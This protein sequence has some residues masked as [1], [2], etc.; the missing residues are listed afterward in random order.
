MSTRR[1]RKVL[2]DLA[3]DFVWSVERTAET[4]AA[5][6]DLDKLEQEAEKRCA[7][8]EAV[9]EGD[10]DAWERLAQ[11]VCDERNSRLEDT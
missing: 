1:I 5:L 3:K 9:A 7:L 10:E 8:A 11:M 4:E 2:E 6:A